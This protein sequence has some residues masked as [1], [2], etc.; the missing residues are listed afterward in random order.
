MNKVGRVLAL[1][2][3][4]VGLMAAGAA[5]SRANLL[6]NGDFETGDL[7]GWGTYNTATGTATTTVSSFDVT[8]TGSSSAAT[9]NLVGLTSGDYGVGDFQGGGL[10]Q[11]VSLAGGTYTLNF[12]AAAAGSGNAD[13]GFF[14]LLFD[15]VVV[16][17]WQ[18]EDINSTLRHTLSA[19]LI[20]V[21]AGTH[22]VAV[23]VSRQ[24][25]PAD[26][27][28]DYIDNVS[29]TAVPEPSSIACFALGGLAVLAARRRAATRRASA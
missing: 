16:D 3:A 8:G 19:T 5:P 17:T 9:F 4:V 24:Y 26:S 6:L 13:G 15:N 28:T 2:T 18:V 10:V 20:G 11:S 27:V 21:A 25:Y 1:A 23:Q 22:S 12:D 29:L 14:S 7:T